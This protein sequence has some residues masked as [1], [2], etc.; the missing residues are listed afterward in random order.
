M[1]SLKIVCF[2]TE[3]ILYFNKKEPMKAWYQRLKKVVGYSLLNEYIL[4]NNL[5]T[6]EYGLVVLATHKKTKEKVA[7]KTVKKQEMNWKQIKSTRKEIE[8]L[9]MC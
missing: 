8:V 1:F 5:G 4:D 2:Q 3:W 6:G 7:I 9:K